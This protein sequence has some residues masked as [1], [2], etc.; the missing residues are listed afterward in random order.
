MWS[1]SRGIRAGAAVSPTTELTK[2]SSTSFAARQ[3]LFRARA[4]RQPKK[5]S[6]ATAVPSSKTPANS[7]PAIGVLPHRRYFRSEAQIPV[8]TTPYKFPF[9]LR[10]VDIDDLNR[11]M[12]AGENHRPKRRRMR[13]G[14]AHERPHLRIVGPQFRRLKRI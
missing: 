4:Q 10:L 12:T 5:P 8:A 2:S 7:W 11:G 13:R 6:T 9:T 14:L 3:S 1:T